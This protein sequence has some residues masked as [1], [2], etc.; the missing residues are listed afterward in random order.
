MLKIKQK[1]GKSNFSG[2]KVAAGYISSFVFGKIGNKNY[3]K[4]LMYSEQIQED[5]R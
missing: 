5:L 3:S 2:N 4:E 1:L